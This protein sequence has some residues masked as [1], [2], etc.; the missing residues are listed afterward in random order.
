[1]DT[2]LAEAAISQAFAVHGKT[3]RGTLASGGVFAMDFD[4]DTSLWLRIRQDSGTAVIVAEL[5]H[6]SL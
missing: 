5:R 6:E 4:D 3:I 2:A 1:M